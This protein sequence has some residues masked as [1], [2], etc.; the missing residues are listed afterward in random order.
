MRYSV[1]LVLILTGCTS[2]GLPRIV[3]GQLP[4]AV[5]TAG[6]DVVTIFPGAT[7]ADDNTRN[8]YGTGFFTDNRT[9]ITA[10]HFYRR[11]LPKNAR[12][13]VVSQDFRCRDATV[14]AI[15][16]ELDLMKIRVSAGLGYGLPLGKTNPKSGERVFV[17]SLSPPRMNDFRPIAIHA[18]LKSEQN[19][20]DET[21]NPWDSP[22]FISGRVT[23][24][25][26]SGAPVVNERGEVVGMNLG[27]FDDC[28]P[29]CRLLISF[30]GQPRRVTFGHNVYVGVP[31]IRRFLRDNP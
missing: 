11:G 14:A 4:R 23:G 24:P 19:A 12:V 27:G 21:T 28:R 9:V 25:G 22:H 17:L 18:Y 5:D 2:G 26:D 20:S 10:A 15:S 30:N 3:A 6:V 31:A 29:N 16:H 13:A 1:F 7:C 8:S